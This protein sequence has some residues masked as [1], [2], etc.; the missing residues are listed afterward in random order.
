MRSEIRDL[1][2]SAA[3]LG[4]DAGPPDGLWGPQTRAGL[5]AMLEAGRG[6][7]GDP[8]AIIHRTFIDLGY[9]S[10]GPVSRI[11][12]PEIDR[13]MRALIAAQ[14]LARAGVVAGAA[15][16]RRARRFGLAM[17]GGFGRALR[18]I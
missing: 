13:A 1:Q 2:S 4:F 6:R 18:A 3:A 15:P 5:T 14:G 16:L 9:L 11:W 17:I 12:T 7:W 10:E 8:M